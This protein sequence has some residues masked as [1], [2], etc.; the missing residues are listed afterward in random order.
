MP[1]SRS[2]V[3][4][5]GGA[6]AVFIVVL[7]IAI[8]QAGG[9]GGVGSVRPTQ[10]SGNALGSDT[11]PVELQEFSDFQCPV[12][13]RFA[14][15]IAPRLIEEYVNTG[16]VRFVYRHFAFIGRESI[17][18]A[19]ATECAGLQGQ[20]WPF[21]DKLF[22]S[23]AGENRGGFGDGRLKQFA[24][25]LGLDQARFDRCLDTDETLQKVRADVQEGEGHGINSTPSFIII[26]G[27][28]GTLIR[29]LRPYED[30]QQVLDAL[31][32]E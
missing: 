9:T 8:S 19:Q 24:G 32:S 3:L 12:C 13:G 26:K 16:K 6:V 25:E 1:L 11:A 17:R 28:N 14:N 4:L 31:L 2:K 30:Y 7:L 10:V 21:H 27:I 20:F 18:A 5:I 22:A 15:E 29:G 23:Q